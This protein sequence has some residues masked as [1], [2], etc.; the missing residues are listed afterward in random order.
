MNAARVAPIVVWKAS[1]H[2]GFRLIEVAR[3]FALAMVHRYEPGEAYSL[4][5]LD[6]D[7]P[8]EAF[9]RYGSRSEMAGIQKGLNPD[10]WQ[11]MLADKGIFYRFSALQG[12]PVPE[13]LG[14]WFR[15]QAGWSP[16]GVPVD[17]PE[18]WEQLILQRF[19]AEF[20]AKPARSVYGDGIMML[21][22]EGTR[23]VD[24]D[25]QGRSVPE[26]LRLLES[27]PSHTSFV[28]QE[29]LDNH[30]GIAGFSGGRGLLSVRVVTQVDGSGVS[31]VLT[32]NLK[33]IVGGNIVSNNRHGQT[34]NLV[35]EIDL[36]RG[37]IL[38]CTGAD[39]SKSG[40][41]TIDRHPD[42]GAAFAG[43]ALP[44]WT[45]VM[46]L[47]L[48][49]AAVFAPVRTVGWDIAITPTGV[50][51]LEGNIWYDPPTH[52]GQTGELMSRMKQLQ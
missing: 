12:L 49:A 44:H 30:P 48:R 35:A 38:H 27:H 9:S 15:G 43:A 21:T 33:V 24:Q 6:P 14:L 32:S 29:R 7:T 45:A 8:T 52:A 5:L 19:P 36:E 42:T 31:R 40:H 23:L 28:F 37:V 46:D 34:G 17:T 10:E 51:L 1:R 3:R 25:G 39:S 20:V 50:R 13:L 18:R 47:A 22:R 11:W 4:G 26:F 41:V 2:S 16:G